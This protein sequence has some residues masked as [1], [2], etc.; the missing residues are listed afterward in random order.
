M[1]HAFKQDTLGN[2]NMSNSAPGQIEPHKLS[3]K[4]FFSSTPIPK[5]LSPINK[6]IR[7]PGVSSNYK[8]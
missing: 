1:L 2:P 4:R 5:L 7:S 3:N 8:L 6:L